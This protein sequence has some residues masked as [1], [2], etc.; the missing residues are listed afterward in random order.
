MSEQPV[1][2]VDLRWQHDQIADEITPALGQVLASG[3]F[4]DGP[5]VKEFESEFASFSGCAH[6]IGCGSGTD[7]LELALRATGIGPGD[8]VIIPVNTFVATA[9]AVMRS[10]ATPVFVDVDPAHMLIDP[11]LLDAAVTARTAA[12]M[13]VHLYGQLAPMAPVLAAA[14]R[15]GLKVIADAAQ[16][17]GATADGRGI[18]ADVIAAGTSFYPGKNLGAAGDAGAVVTDDESIADLV[19]SIGHHGAG[20][21]RYHHVRFGCTSRLDTIHA[22]VLRAKLARLE[23]WNEL[24]RA[25]ASFY[26]ELLGDVEGVVTPRVA[27]GNTP[28]WHLYVVRVEERDAVL[29]RLHAAGIGAG[30]HYPIPLHRQPVFAGSVATEQDFPVATEA[31][32]R[33]L[34][35]PIYPGITESQQERVVQ[36]LRSAIA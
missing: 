23:K 31:A 16:A 30:V 5:A 27:A 12:V 10:G 18:A 14:R 15:H 22:I 36:G 8:E 3:G 32:A 34:S 21:D 33:I 4:I 9:E 7:A 6:A 20:D 13:P 28:V 11:E 26:D 1:P 17:Q 19:R 35:L 24:R 29:A 2:L 25:A